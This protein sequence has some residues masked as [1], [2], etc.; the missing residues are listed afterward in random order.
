MS[1]LEKIILRMI[2][3][4]SRK[5]CRQAKSYIFSGRWSKTQNG[6]QNRSYPSL[7]LQYFTLFKGF[8]KNYIICFEDMNTMVVTRPTFWGPFVKTM[9]KGVLKQVNFGT[10]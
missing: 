10:H 2:L 4:T 9:K 8:K 3:S 5:R 7:K 1:I 6:D